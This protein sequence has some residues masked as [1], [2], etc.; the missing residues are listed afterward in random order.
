MRLAKVE[1]E[2]FDFEEASVAASEL[3]RQVCLHFDDA[4]AL[5]VSWT[6]ERQHGS[7]DQPYSIGLSAGSFFKDEPAAVVDAS[8]APQ[9]LRHVGRDVAV[10]YQLAASPVFECQVIEVRSVG[11]PTFVFSLGLDRVGI[12]NTSPIPED[13]SS[14]VGSR[15]GNT[16]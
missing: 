13:T 5:F 4:P 9:W 8:K 6:S 2:F 12:S 10:G 14:A 1:Y 7:D 3:T 11:D 16:A 15:R